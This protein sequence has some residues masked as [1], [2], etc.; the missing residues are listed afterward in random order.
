MKESSR[1]ELSVVV[2][3]LSNSE[4]IA[5]S[6]LTISKI[7]LGQNSRLTGARTSELRAPKILPV[8]SACLNHSRNTGFSRLASILSC[9]IGRLIK[10]FIIK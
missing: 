5:I 7:R 8:N 2:C 1:C 4:I 6:L 10:N 9:L 3:L